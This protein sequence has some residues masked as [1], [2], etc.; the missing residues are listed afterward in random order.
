MLTSYASLFHNATTL[1]GYSHDSDFSPR[2]RASV[3]GFVPLLSCSSLLHVKMPWKKQEKVADS[4][5]DQVSP[6][7]ADVSA[8]V[9]SDA[10][11]GVTKEK[12]SKAF[13]PKKGKATPKRNEQERKHGV[14]R[15]AYTAPATP[16]EARKQRKELKA[17]M[18]K[19][20][21]KAMKQRQKDEANRERRRANQRMMAGDEDYLMDRDKG[22]EK[23]FVRDWIDSRRYMM[24]F[25]LPLALLVIVIMI[26]GMS[27][28]SIANLASLVMMVVF[29]IMIG[30]GIWLGRHI[31]REVNERFP[32]NPHGKFSLGLYAFTRA[33]MIRRLRTPAPQKQIGDS[34]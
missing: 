6:Q 19:E 26:F 24:N 29:L 13:T 30:E 25:F 31:N 8:E 15:S 33:T 28:P 18:S 4:A 32:N 27:N 17:S 11:G 3:F 20:E 16:G 10:D 2:S 9:D 14:R 1:L 23:R 12:N 21:Y 5:E 7:D 22:P 34:V